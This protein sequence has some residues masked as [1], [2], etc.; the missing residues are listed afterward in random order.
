MED[1]RRPIPSI[2]L[3]IVLGIC[4]L[5]IGI[6]EYLRFL[7]TWGFSATDLIVIVAAL[8][9]FW[10]FVRSFTMDSFNGW[11]SIVFI[12]SEFALLTAWLLANWVI[13]PKGTRLYELT[14]AWWDLAFTG[15]FVG[16]LIKLR[17][18][19]RP[20]PPTVNSKKGIS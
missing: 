2:I 20:T 6:V 1:A 7:E 18:Q 8:A 3:P 16:W 5:V 14:H 19:N 4:F 9:M 17:R 12:I 10:F 13:L 11:K 15:I